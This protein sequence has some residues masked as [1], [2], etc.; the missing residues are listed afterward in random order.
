MGALSEQQS[1][2]KLLLVDDAA[3]ARDF[4]LAILAEV[5]SH[6]ELSWRSDYATG[7]E[8]LLSGFFDVCLLDYQLGA[9]SGLDLLREAKSR[10]ARLPII[11]LTGHGSAALDHEAMHAGAADYLVKGD[12][13]AASLDR[14]VRYLVERTR[15]EDARRDS[16]ER[17]ALAMEGSNDGL[18]DWRVGEKDIHLSSRTLGQHD[19]LI[20]LGC[21]RGQ[22]F[23]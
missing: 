19:A 18:W 12:F 13:S 15:A 2:V 3:F 14:I 7:L 21:T 20:A 23:R 1:R 4:L 16:E 6:I 11:M 8:A 10:G 22:G 5:D 9:R 17:Y